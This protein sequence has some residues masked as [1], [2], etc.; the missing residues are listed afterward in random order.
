MQGANTDIVRAE[1]IVSALAEGI[2]TT[3]GEVLSDNSVCNK[4]D[5]VRTL[6]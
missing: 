2:D 4:V 5:A 1:D 6:Q 3:I